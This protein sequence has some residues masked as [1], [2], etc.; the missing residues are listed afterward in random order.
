MPTITLHRSVGHSIPAICFQIH[1]LYS[2]WRLSCSLKFTSLMQQL[3]LL[4]VPNLIWRKSNEGSNRMTQ[5]IWKSEQR[6][7]HSSGGESLRSLSMNTDWRD[8]RR[9]HR[10][11]LL[12][13]R[14]SWSPHDKWCSS[15][16]SDSSRISV[17]WLV[18]EVISLQ[19]RKQTVGT[20]MILSP[21]WSFQFHPEQLRKF[22][23][24]CEFLFWNWKA[25]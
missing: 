1:R 13:R 15:S 24:K 21:I 14:R 25:K 11:Q 6:K 19:N 4:R 7:W 23:G 16:S 10:T 12:R 9:N 18:D 3:P 2:I 22:Q 17:R 5:C 20:F 8:R